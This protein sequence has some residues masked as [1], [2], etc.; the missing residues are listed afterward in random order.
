MSCDDHGLLSPLRVLG[1]RTMKL[2][3]HAS[4]QLHVHFCNQTFLLG[5]AKVLG[6]IMLT[7]TSGT[8]RALRS[9]LQVHAPL[10]H[11]GSYVEKLRTAAYASLILARGNISLKY[12]QILWQG[13]THRFR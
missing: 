6:A 1:R 3:L 4:P 9:N 11:P 7:R 5:S 10:G 8:D 12:V 13:L 2:C